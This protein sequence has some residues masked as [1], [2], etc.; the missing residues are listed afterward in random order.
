MTTIDYSMASWAFP[1][2]YATQHWADISY[3][4]SWR[5]KAIHAIVAVGEMIPVA[6][7]IVA[8]F[9]RLVWQ[10]KSQQHANLEAS[11]RCFQIL[12]H[13]ISILIC[14]STRELA[15]TSSTSKCFKHA[16]DKAFR[17]VIREEKTLSLTDLKD[18]ARFL[19]Q[20]K[21]DSNLI[22]VSKL[23]NNLT[24]LNLSHLYIDDAV[25]S[26]LQ[27]FSSQ[28]LSQIVSLDLSFTSFENNWQIS[29]LFIKTFLPEVNSRDTLFPN[30]NFIN[31]E[32]S[33]QIEAGDLSD[34]VPFLK[35]GTGGVIL[36]KGGRYQGGWNRGIPQGDGILSKSGSG[37]ILAYWENG[38]IKGECTL[39]TEDDSYRGLLKEGL[40]EG[41]GVWRDNEG[42]TYTGE[43]K[44]GLKEG[45]GTWQ[46]VNGSSYTGEWIGGKRVGHGV[47]KS[48]QN[49][50]YEGSWF[51]N[52]MHGWGSFFYPDASIYEGS[53]KNDMKE[54]KGTL[55]LFDKTIY[56][57]EWSMDVPDGHGT[58]I[59]PNGETYEGFC[60]RGILKTFPLWMKII[61]Y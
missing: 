30:L 59:F 38:I 58:Y 26:V 4:K 56:I 57:G 27:S 39:Q 47:S 15:I 23:L 24:A 18:S 8:H 31:L 35:T 11:R 48:L 32:Q 61:N 21:N 14:L 46:S 9:D 43:W 16:A 33:P 42:N 53:W 37:Q 54:G 29:K 40:K 3:E 36:C 20:G 41:V 49:G 50:S 25:C 6:N 51:N 28:R 13:T 10:P 45:K 5:G 22:K 34:C 2:R 19:T 7:Y 55:T 17:K 44:E 12:D 1:F 52:E 60:I